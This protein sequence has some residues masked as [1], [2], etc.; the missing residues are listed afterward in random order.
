MDCGEHWT[1]PGCASCQEVL[2]SAVASTG[3]ISGG[4]VAPVGAVCKSFSNPASG[5]MGVLDMSWGE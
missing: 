5:E 4:M 2:P 3:S 1:L